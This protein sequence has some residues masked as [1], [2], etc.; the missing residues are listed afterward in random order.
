MKTLGLT[1]VAFAA[2][3]TPAFA[4]GAVDAAKAHIAA[5]GA[6]NVTAIDADYTAA[7]TLQWVGGPLDGAYVGTDKIA[8]VWGKFTKGQGKLATKISRISES[9]NPAGSTVV[10]NVVF[11]GKA[12]IKVRYVMTYRAGKLVNE[13]WQIA[14]KANY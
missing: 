14:P 13:I 7:S 1:L 4:S 5:I 12:P 11:T 10:A 6:A 9:A 3:A 2:L 8:G